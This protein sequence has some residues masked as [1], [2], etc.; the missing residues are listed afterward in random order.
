[1][2]RSVASVLVKLIVRLHRH[3]SVSLHD[4]CRDLFVALPGS[5]LNHNAALCLHRHVVCHADTFVVVDFLDRSHCVFSKNI[6]QSRLR[7]SFRHQYN[8]FLSKLVGCPRN[9]ASVVSVRSGKE[10]CLTEFFS[11]LIGCQDIVRKLRN[12]FSRLLCDVAC[13]CKRSA[14]HFKG[15]QTE[16]VRFIF[17]INL[18]K[19]EKISHLVELRKRRHAVLREALVKCAGFCNFIKRHNFQIRIFCF[20]HVIDCPF[21]CFHVEKPPCE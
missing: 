13:H 3:R 10:S 20:R 7:R 1:M 16:A 18:A 2:G 5:I 4:P 19:P 8:G 9:A 6:V 15:I 14:E 11:E 21:D 17:D 12:I